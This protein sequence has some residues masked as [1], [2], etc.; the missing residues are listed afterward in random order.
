MAT[1]SGEAL[2]V[3]TADAAGEALVIEPDG[4]VLPA[5]RQVLL[6]P[7]ALDRTSGR[8][9]REVVVDGW[10]FEVDVEPDR[11]ARLREQAARASGHAAQDGRLEIRAVIPGRVVAVAVN[12]GDRVEAAGQLLVVEAM[13]MQNE[14]RAP[15]AGTVAKVAV[16]AGQNVELRDLLIVLE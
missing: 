2:R 9:R 6:L 11:R 1:V 16:G 14:I 15:R 3:M 13:K 7:S 5:D 8:R 4:Q 12:P 10:R